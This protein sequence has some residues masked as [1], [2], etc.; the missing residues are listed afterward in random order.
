MERIHIAETK[1]RGTAPLSVGAY[2]RQP[3]RSLDERPVGHRQTGNT[4]LLM[5]AG[6]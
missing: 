6:S 2:A 1:L 5:V 4:G 3:D